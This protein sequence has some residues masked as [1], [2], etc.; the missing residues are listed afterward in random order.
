[1]EMDKYAL[2]GVAPAVFTVAA[3]EAA[4]FAGNPCDET[5]DAVRGGGTDERCFARV[6]WKG[7]GYLFL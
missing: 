2:A 4:D 7:I 1:M 3:E 5:T 6:L